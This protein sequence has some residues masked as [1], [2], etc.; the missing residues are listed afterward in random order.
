MSLPRHAFAQQQ[1]RIG[2][3]LVTPGIVVAVGRA[4]RFVAVYRQY[5]IITTLSVGCSPGYTVTVTGHHATVIVVSGHTLWRD[6]MARI[7]IRWRE[8]TRNIHTRFTGNAMTR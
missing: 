6:V 8:I 3:T 4:R 1:W 2:A 7:I 5:V